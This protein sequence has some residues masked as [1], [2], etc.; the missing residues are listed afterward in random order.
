ME[1]V[2]ADGWEQVED[3]YGRTRYRPAEPFK[4]VPEVEHEEVVENVRHL[5]HAARVCRAEDFPV[6]HVV[7]PLQEY[8]AGG[9]Q[10]RIVPQ[11]PQPLGWR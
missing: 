9:L 4:L 8:A 7:L 3:Q 6:G 5:T 11:R 10:L 2:T 1:S